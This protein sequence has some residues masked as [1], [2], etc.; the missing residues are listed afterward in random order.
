VEIYADSFFSLIDDYCRK[1]KDWLAWNQEIVFEWGNMSISGL[2]FQWASAIKIQLCCKG[3][4]F[5]QILFFRWSMTIANKAKI[6]YLR[7][8]PLIWYFKELI[9]RP[10]G[11]K[12]LENN[13]LYSYYKET[14]KMIQ[15][16][17]SCTKIIWLW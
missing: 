7:K 1:G 6:R 15:R 5:T 2:L 13:F 3:W 10:Y 8:K 9:I 14:K 4:K 17:R 16:E 12:T 11:L